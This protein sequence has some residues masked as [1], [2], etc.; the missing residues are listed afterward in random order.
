PTIGVNAAVT[1]M[2]PL[3][4]NGNA[5]LISGINSLPAQWNP[6]ECPAL[7]AGNTDDVVGIRSAAGSGVV[8][9]DLN[10]LDGYPAKFVENDPSI[11][12]ATFQNFLDYTFATLA[13]QP[14]VKV[15]P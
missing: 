6:A 14:G 2:D 11:T 13:A 10:N 1:V 12:D 5:F 7:E 15:L 3:N 8:S 4:L 9:H